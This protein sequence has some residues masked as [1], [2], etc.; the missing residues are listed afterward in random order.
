MKKY[1]L[2]LAVLVLVSLF[3]ITVLA[4]RAHTADLL[5]FI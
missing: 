4:Y 5:F 2:L 3:M 1:Y